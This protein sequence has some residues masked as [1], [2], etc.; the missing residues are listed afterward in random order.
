MSEI[1][2][3]FASKGKAKPLPTQIASSSKATSKAEK[4]KNKNKKSAVAS[5]TVVPSRKRQLPETVVDTSHELAAPPKRQ[6]TGK[7][8]H[9]QAA[10]NGRE[11]LAAFQDSR[12]TSGS[13]LL[14]PSLFQVC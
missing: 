4:K 1:E 6:K 5:Y 3:I 12:G 13:E 10:E 2:D 9:P 14:P 7:E 8:K 11:N